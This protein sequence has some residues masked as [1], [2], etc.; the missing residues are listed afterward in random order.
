LC[1]AHRNTLFPLGEFS[2]LAE[3]LVEAR[4]LAERLGDQRRL[5]RSLVYQ[6]SLRSVILGEH[7]GAI[8][9]GQ[10]ACAIA[11]AVGDLGLRVTA[12]YFLGQALWLAGDLRAAVETLRVAVALAKD[13]PPGERFGSVGLAAAVAWLWL[14]VVL[15]ERGEF[16]GA[17]DA[18]E[19]ALRIAQ[20]A[21]HS[22]SEVW[23]R[24]SLGIAHLYR[25][26]FAQAT[27]VLE[28]GLAL[29]RAV[30]LRLALPA[31]TSALGCA[32]LWSRRT[33]DAL[34]LL[35]EAVDGITAMGMLG[36]K[37]WPVTALAEAYLI[38]GR[39]AEAQE[40]AQQAAALARAHRAQGLEARALRL[41]GDIL[42]YDS[43]HME[44]AGDSY[45]QALALAT[46]L[47]MRPLVA[48]CHLSLG[49]LHGSTGEHE[50]ARA[51]LATA[52]T[53]YREMDMPFWREQ[54]GVEMSGMG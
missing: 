29:C 16:A 47:E 13:T 11:E 5:A 22:Y 52:G 49:K 28:Q 6:T 10:D 23:A 3:V 54:A 18:G 35:E 43:A 1:F 46:E 32:Y 27:G 38:V 2:R 30:E 37:P 50:D 21:S 53:L 41:L 4:A 24:W 45:R 15:A 39:I 17:I 42:G 51:H 19:E 31:V 25:G 8:E 36:F 12:R 44:Q 33:A 26:D 7:A 34:P 48:H 14:S 9:A 40:Q 20:A